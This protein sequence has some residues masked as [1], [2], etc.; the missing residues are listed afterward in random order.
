MSASVIGALVFKDF[1][2]YLRNR[3][4]P[5]ITIL[6][7]VAYVAIYLIMPATV[8]ETLEIGLYGSHIPRAFEQAEQ[9]G[10]K[11]AIF[12]SGAAL[13]AAITEGDVAA[14]IAIPTDLAEGIAAGTRPTLKVYFA[15]DT[16]EEL[17]A[18]I[19]IL[20]KE[21]FYLEV[22]QQ[23]S[24]EVTTEIL[25]RDMVGDQI[26]PRDRLVPL[27]AI[28]LLLVE[29]LGMAS[30]IS[31]EV[32]RGTLRALLV[33]PLTITDLFIAKGIVGIALAFGQAALF[34]AIVGGLSSQPSLILTT[35]LL[36]ALMVTGI[37]FLMASLCKDLMSVLAWGIVVLVALSL[38]TMSILF[39]GTLTNWIEFIPS[40]YLVDT[41]H[42]AANF[43]AG[44]GETWSNLLVLLAF[45]FVVFAGGILAL[46]RKFQ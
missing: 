29:T 22:G 19:E 21:L 16:P 1:A 18:P 20:I 7:L 45:D 43:G 44:W 33:T 36:G 31:E 5:V 30:L 41:M 46:R 24:V 38:P 15:S 8:D 11:L 12:E 37:G 4:F 35:L 3:L 28:L 40:Y 14:G 39:P 17:K 6:G 25:G 26:P 13:R 23:L 42:R 10:L 34:V 2:L 9:E 32:E 27:F